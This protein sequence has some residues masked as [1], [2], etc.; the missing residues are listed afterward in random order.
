MIR[1]CEFFSCVEFMHVSIKKLIYIMVEIWKRVGGRH[2][3]K[4]ADL[5][6]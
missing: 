6:L 2:G 5:V 3:M 1:I 4:F